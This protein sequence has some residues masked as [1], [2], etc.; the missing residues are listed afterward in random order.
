MFKTILFDLD[1]T[2]ID[3]FSAIHKSVNHVQ[4][5]LGLK[6]STY[7][8]VKK[9]VGGSVGLTL[10][11]L[12]N[13]AELET[14]LPIFKEHFEKV[15]MDE[16]FVLP[17]ILELLDTLKADH[18]QMAVLTNKIGS[19]AR[20]TLKHL[21]IDCFFDCTLGAEDTPYRKPSPQFTE[22]IL[23]S[24]NANISETCLIGDSPF[25]WETGV[26][27]NMPVYLVATGTHSVSDLKRDTNSDFIYSDIYALAENIFNYKLSNNE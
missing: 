20:S 8:N 16:V 12:F 14:T 11:R 4:R 7:I 13:D 26:S 3:Q 25:D 6:E 27:V 21:K 15:M 24:L 19:H 9:A 22:H 23:N 2:L 10:K 5:Q 17:G 18:I 1:G